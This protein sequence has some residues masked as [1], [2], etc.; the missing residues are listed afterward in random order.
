MRVRIFLTVAGFW[1]LPT[2][3]HAQGEPACPADERPLEATELKM[4]GVQSTG[5][6]HNPQEADVVVD[7]VVDPD[8]SVS[9]AKVVRSETWP[10]RAGGPAMPRY[11]DNAARE[12]VASRKYASRSQSCRAEA[13]IRFRFGR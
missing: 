2:V 3:A 8:G 10:V 5:E 1:F 7:F 11:F 6:V 13:I 4:P 9:A 12:H